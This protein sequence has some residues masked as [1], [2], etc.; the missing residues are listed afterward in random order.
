MRKKKKL[1]IV[2]VA[3]IIT[4]LCITVFLSVKHKK[5]EVKMVWE[6]YLEVMG[7]DVDSGNIK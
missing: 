4:I 7:R 5:Q 1:S 6:V 3:V 2:L